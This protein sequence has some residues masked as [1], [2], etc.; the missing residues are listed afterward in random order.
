MS[1]YSFQARRPASCLCGLPF[2]KSTSLTDPWR[3]CVSALQ[4]TKVLLAYEVV[5]EVA[6]GVASEDPPGV[7]AEAAAAA[8]ISTCASAAQV[9][10]LQSV[11][12]LVYS[13]RMLL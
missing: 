7:A 2:G 1:G 9:L 10:V 8:A 11:L 5:P 3:F 12:V 4:V 13:N 6:S